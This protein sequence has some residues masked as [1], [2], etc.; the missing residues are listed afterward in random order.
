MDAFPLK[1]F[2]I[3]K[4]TVYD[5]KSDPDDHI[6]YYQQVMAYWVYDDAIMCIM[7]PSS[8]GHME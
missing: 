6:R 3:I 8:L 5:G 4:F 2:S 7:F 1:D